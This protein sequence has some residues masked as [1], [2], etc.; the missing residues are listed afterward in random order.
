MTLTLRRI[1]RLAACLLAML[2]ASCGSSSKSK[3]KGLPANLPSIPIHASASTPSHSMSH[4]EYP[5]DSGG[6]Y[7]TAWAAEGEKKAGRDPY[8]STSISD[9]KSSH[10]GGSSSSKKKTSSS[11][12]KTS[13]KSKSGS[14]VS[15]TVKKGDTLS[16]IARKYGTTVAKIKAANGLKSDLIRDGKS[17]KVPK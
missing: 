6:N 3:I 15:Y 16:G 12:K 7:I 2:L 9:W 4:A 1:S 17:L 8:A 10:H 11:G 14:S 13:S 5:F